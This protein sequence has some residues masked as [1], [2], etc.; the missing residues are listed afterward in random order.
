M[1]ASIEDLDNMT[2]S[3]AIGYLKTKI[4]VHKL[5]IRWCEKMLGQVPKGSNEQEKSK[6]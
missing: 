3:E 1:S 5:G 2:L 4:H 6:P